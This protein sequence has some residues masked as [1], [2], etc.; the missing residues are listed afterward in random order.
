M[1]AYAKKD[2]DCQPKTARRTVISIEVHCKSNLG[3]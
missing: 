1:G 3:L 2:D